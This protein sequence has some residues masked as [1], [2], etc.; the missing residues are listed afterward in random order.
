MLAAR[1][2]AL[3]FT[4]LFVLLSAAAAFA[5]AERMRSLEAAVGDEVAIVVAAVPIEAH[6]PITAAALATARLPR[7][8]LR[9]GLLTDPSA[10]VGWSAAVP[11]KAGE[12]LTRA[13]LLKPLGDDALRAYTLTTSTTVVLEPGLLPGDRVDLLVAIHDKSSDRVERVLTGAV[14]I[15]VQNDPR[16]RSVTLA[17]TVEQAVAVMQAENFGRQLRLLRPEAS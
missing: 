14:V 17:L 11:V 6:T 8:Y 13:M 7:R 2:W 12:V 1:R 3:L 5:A 16:S 15:R 10:A 9:P 4:I